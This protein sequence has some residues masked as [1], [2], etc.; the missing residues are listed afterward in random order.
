MYL[1]IGGHA[2]GKLAWAKEHFGLTD[3]Q[4]L[5]G[6][7]VS[8]DET[9]FRFADK[10]ALYNLQE[11]LYR[12]LEQGNSSRIID[13]LLQLPPEAII[14]CNEVGAG[15]VPMDRQERQRRDLVGR[16]CCRLAEQAKEVW[17]IYCGLPQKIK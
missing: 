7:A 3:D 6:A 11:L 8:L 16:T 17:R 13:R 4:I 1:I 2:Q 10:R 5:D 15:L 9:G 12:A 14:I